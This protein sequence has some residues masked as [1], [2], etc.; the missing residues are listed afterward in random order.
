MS[1]F[2]EVG[3][4]L[5]PAGPH[6]TGGIARLNDMD[7]RFVAP[8]LEPQTARRLRAALA[9]SPDDVEVTLDGADLALTRYAREA[10]TELLA[11]LATGKSVAIGTLEDLLTTSQAAE[12]LGVSDTYVRRL[13]DAGELTIEMR[14]THRRFV[15]ADVV[16]YRSRLRSVKQSES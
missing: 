5:C 2:V 1:S 6:P 14:G 13:A 10:V 3:F 16:A 9:A 15:L 12:L 4:T 7:Y 11:Q 8:A